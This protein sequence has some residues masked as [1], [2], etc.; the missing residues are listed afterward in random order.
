ME[1][2]LIIIVSVEG[3][4]VV[5]VENIPD[6]IVIEVRDF[7][8]VWDVT[9]QGSFKYEEGFKDSGGNWYSKKLFRKEKK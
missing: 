5:D 2:E 6:N 7:D 4:G 8:D 3:G 1:K 9:K